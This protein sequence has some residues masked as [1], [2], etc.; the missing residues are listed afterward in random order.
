MQQ[1]S[2]AASATASSLSSRAVLHR[3][4]KQ[5]VASSPSIATSAIV[6]TGTPAILVF[7]PPPPAAA[8]PSLVIF[9]PGVPASAAACAGRLPRIVA[10]FR[11]AG[12]LGSSAPPGHDS[13]LT[14]ALTTEKSPSLCNKENS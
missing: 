4:T 8:T 9:R 5:G 10:A 7:L 14:R 12:T 1:Q 6:P 13:L 3:C 2:K 11:T